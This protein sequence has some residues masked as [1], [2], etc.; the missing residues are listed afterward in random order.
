MIPLDIAETGYTLTGSPGSPKVLPRVEPDSGSPARSG[1]GSASPSTTP[2]DEVVLRRQL[3][4]NPAGDNGCEGS[5]NDGADDR[6]EP[7]H[8][9]Q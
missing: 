8:G 4:G 2:G 1:S 7:R 9:K 5:D 3:S 6:A